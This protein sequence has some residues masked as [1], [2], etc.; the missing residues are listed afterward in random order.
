MS[1]SAS[2][3]SSSLLASEIEAAARVFASINRPQAIRTPRT[4]HFCRAGHQLIAVLCE[5]P[6]PYRSQHRTDTMEQAIASHSGRT[7]LRAPQIVERL[8]AFLLGHLSETTT[9]TSLC[10]VTGVSERSLRNA[11]HAVCGTSPKRYQTR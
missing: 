4:C 11:C 3:R 6:K 10:R 8:D 2:A 7:R 9:I 5:G 1:I